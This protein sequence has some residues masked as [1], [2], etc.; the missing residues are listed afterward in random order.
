MFVCCILR[1]VT[2]F[3][4]KIMCTLQVR[5]DTI[6]WIF[7]PRV[8]HWQHMRRTCHIW[9]NPFWSSA[10]DSKKYCEIIILCLS[11]V[12][13]AQRKCWFILLHSPYF[14]SSFE[15]TTLGHW[16]SFRVESDSKRHYYV[17]SIVTIYLIDKSTVWQRALS[18]LAV[19][20]FA[21]TSYLLPLIAVD[22][23]AEYSDLFL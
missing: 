11:I 14:L 1:K 16:S 6:E 20:F 2:N 10:V 8:H 3:S 19:L 12:K 9:A 15:F 22:P 21:V 23:S 17:T 13:Y 4:W 7:P 5:R 18:K